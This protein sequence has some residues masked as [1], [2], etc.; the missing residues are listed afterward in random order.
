MFP[1]DSPISNAIK[2]G[3]QDNQDLHDTIVKIDHL[4]VNRL[5]NYITA[6]QKLIILT[7]IHEPIFYANCGT[8]PA[9]GIKKKNASLYLLLVSE[10]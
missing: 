1:Y 8:N 10:I 6:G 5:D 4:I 9:T 2:Q 7:G 3:F